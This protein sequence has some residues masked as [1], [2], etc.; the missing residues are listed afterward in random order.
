MRHLV[1]SVEDVGE[2]EHV[3][4]V[5]GVGDGEEEVVLGDEGTDLVAEASNLVPAGAELVAGFD[6]LV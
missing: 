2:T 6:G 4:V 1:L 3:E 5:E